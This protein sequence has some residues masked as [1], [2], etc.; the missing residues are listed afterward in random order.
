MQCNARIIKKNILKKQEVEWTNEV[1]KVLEDDEG[2]GRLK[3]KRRDGAHI[4]KMQEDITK[5]TQ[6]RS[7]INNMD[8]DFLKKEIRK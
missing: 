5:F 2:V 4:K 1:I 8:M 3:A 7:F 6:D